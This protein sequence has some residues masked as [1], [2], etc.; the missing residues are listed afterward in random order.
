MRVNAMSRTIVVGDIHG[1][2][3]EFKEL[4]EKVSLSETDRV[5]AVGDLIVKGPRNREVLEMFD[6]RDRR[7]S[8]VIGNQ[9]LALLRH[10]RGQHA[11]LT[12]AHRKAL[13]ELERGPR[14]LRQN[15]GSSAVDD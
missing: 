11:D 6:G 14:Y 3:D 10:W 4:L 9:D 15:S 2:Y 8:S 1:C 7:F 5:V 12:D 13:A